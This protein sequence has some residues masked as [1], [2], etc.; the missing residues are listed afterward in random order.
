MDLTERPFDDL[1][2]EEQEQAAQAQRAKEEAENTRHE[3]G[4]VPY[5]RSVLG[6]DGMWWWAECPRC[7]KVVLNKDG[8]GPARHWNKEAK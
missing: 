5:F 3:I 2:D 6:P 7:G 1:T 8:L 4:L